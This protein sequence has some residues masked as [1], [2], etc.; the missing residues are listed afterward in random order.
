[1]I[2]E[3]LR[4][5]D[6]AYGL[7]S[8]SL[9]YFNAAGADPE[10]EIGEWHDPETHLV[11]LAIMAALGSRAD[12]CIY[13]DDYPTEDGTCI[14]DFIHVSDLADAHIRALDL[15]MSA[16]KSDSFNLGNGSGY[17]V[18]DVLNKVREA[19]GRDIKVVRAPRRAGDPPILV[20]DSRKAAKSLGWTP[21]Y[22]GLDAIVGT[23]LSWHSKAPSGREK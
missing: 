14:R 21:Q 3:I 8:I 18:K 13:G 22:P 16:E 15:V 6:G 10:G 19:S 20:S 12:F 2:E 23:A 11:P 17:S 1:M 7:K 4:D 5:Y 9:R